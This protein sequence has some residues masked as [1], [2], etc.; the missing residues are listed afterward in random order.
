MQDKSSDKQPPTY[1]KPV[2]VPDG[3]RHTFTRELRCFGPK[4][5]NCSFAAHHE[6]PDIPAR[7]MAIRIGK[8]RKTRVWGR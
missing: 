5:E 8:L 1:R 6:E 7:Q 4:L 3:A 2:S